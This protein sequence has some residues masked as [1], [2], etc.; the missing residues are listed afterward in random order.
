MGRSSGRRPDPLVQVLA[1]HS[2]LGVVGFFRG[3]VPIWRLLGFGVDGLGARLGLV[4]GSVVVVGPLALGRFLLLLW[5][6][7]HF[8]E[9]QIPNL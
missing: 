4:S 1:W 2:P 5:L 8:L 9:S 7:L 3:V 6:D